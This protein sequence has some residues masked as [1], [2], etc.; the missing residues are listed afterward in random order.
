[1]IIANS[2]CSTDSHQIDGFPKS[3]AITAFAAQNIWANKP[4]VSQYGLPDH[5]NS[6][7][8]LRDYKQSVQLAIQNKDYLSIAGLLCLAPPLSAYS[9]FMTQ[10]AELAWWIYLAFSWCLAA[11]AICVNGKQHHSNC[12]E[13]RAIETF[14][15]DLTSWFTEAKRRT[16]YDFWVRELPM[17]AGTSSNPI[18]KGHVFAREVAFLLNEDK[19]TPMLGPKG[20]DWGIDIF[21]GDPIRTVVQCKHNVSS[22]S[23]KPRRASPSVVRELYAT[24]A[25]VCA[26]SGL[27]VCLGVPSSKPGNQFY[28]NRSLEEGR[29]LEFWHVGHLMYLAATILKKEEMIEAIHFDP[30]QAHLFDPT[31]SQPLPWSNAGVAEAFDAEDEEEDHDMLNTL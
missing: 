1:M 11:L 21:L 25:A 26:T 22:K 9:H 16:Q 31:N 20:N 24:T 8:R 18:S 3:S 15:A 10:G 27:L 17:M 12:K 13:L 6:K 29:P 7:E 2:M 14:A 28:Y 4:S 23:G 19:R 30:N 5:V